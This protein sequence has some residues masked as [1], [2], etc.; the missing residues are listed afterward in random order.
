MVLSGIEEDKGR[1]IVQCLIQK[2]VA[3]SFAIHRD[4]YIRFSHFTVFIYICRDI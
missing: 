1:N 3:V 4:D 2:N